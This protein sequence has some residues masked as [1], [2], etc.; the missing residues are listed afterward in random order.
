MRQVLNFSIMGED[1]NVYEVAVARETHDL[2]NLSASCSCGKAQEGDFCAH[3]FDVLEGVTGSLV[4]GNLDDLRALRE[5]IRGTD[6]DVAMQALSKAKTEL[7]LA[8]EKVAKCR[9]MLVR[10]MLD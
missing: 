3:R 7:L 1:E 10:R 5:W 2:G 4:S 6:I 8:H 9:A